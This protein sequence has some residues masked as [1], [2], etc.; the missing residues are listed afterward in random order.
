MILFNDAGTLVNGGLS[1][2][3]PTQWPTCGRIRRRQLQ[4]RYP[5]CASTATT[6]AK[7]ANNS[8]SSR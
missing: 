4:T 2:L 5:Y 7:T 6:R 3:D 1:P 8:N